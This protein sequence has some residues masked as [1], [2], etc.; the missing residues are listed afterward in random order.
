MYSQN[1]SDETE[2]AQVVLPYQEPDNH[3]HV[4]Q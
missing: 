4:N 1:P 3:G 2:Y